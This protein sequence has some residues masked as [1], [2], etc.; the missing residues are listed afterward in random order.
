VGLSQSSA[1]VIDDFFTR[2]R[3]PAPQGSARCRSDFPIGC[4]SV[5]CGTANQ[6]QSATQS[7]T[8]RIAAAHIVL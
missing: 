2:L 8:P 5:G 4:H 1:D 7:G 6:T 3:S